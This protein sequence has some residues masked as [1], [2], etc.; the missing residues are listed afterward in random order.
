ML[1]TK[2]F[3]F[4][5]AHFLTDYYGKCERLHGHTYKLAVTLQGRVQKNG[6]VL[7]F[8][9]LKRIVKKQVLDKLDHYLLNDIIKNPS[10]ERVV[11]WIWD[12]LKDL[13]KILKAEMD[14]PNLGAEIKALLKKSDRKGALKK[15]EFDKTLRL[16]EL[17]LWET[18]TSSVTYRGE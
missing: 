1:V 14:D 15:A 6:L 11:M 8:V 16:Y 13:Q 3:D 7:D 2:E 12:Q 17:K 18:A 4:D 5:A 9:V 10:A